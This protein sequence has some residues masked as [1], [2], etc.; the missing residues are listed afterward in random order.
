M[1]R[2]QVRITTGV[3]VLARI[4][5]RKYRIGNWRSPYRS[6]RGKMGKYMERFRARAY[7]YTCTGRIA[8]AFVKDN[9]KT[10]LTAHSTALRTDIDQLP[11]RDPITN[12]AHPHPHFARPPARLA[13]IDFPYARTALATSPAVCCSRTPVHCVSVATA[14][15]CSIIN[16]Q[17]HSERTRPN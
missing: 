11:A 9:G 4:A 10:E 8:H 7:N 5:F 17:C 1:L 12:Q 2:E 15:C 14:A 3:R 16:T 6:D 13:L